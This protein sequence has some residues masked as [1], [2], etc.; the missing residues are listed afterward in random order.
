MERQCIFTNKYIG[1]LRE[2]VENGIIDG[3]REEEFTYDESQLLVLPKRNKPERLLDS[4]LAA[5]TE[6]DRAVTLFSAYDDL[7]PLEASYAP[8]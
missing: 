8:F 3:Y 7:T 2:N 4:M 6:F 5:E 1:I